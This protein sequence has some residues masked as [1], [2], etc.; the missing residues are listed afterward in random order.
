MV[1]IILG[2]F[3]GIS[4]LNLE[5]KKIFG[6]KLKPVL[7]SLGDS[8]SVRNWYI[9]HSLAK[10]LFAMGDES[11]SAGA[12]YQCDTIVNQESGNS[13]TLELLDGSRSFYIIDEPYICDGCGSSCAIDGFSVCSYCEDTGFC[14]ACFSLLRAGNLP[15]NLC[16]P[17]HNLVLITPRPQDVK[18]RSLE[19]RSMLYVDGE[20]LTVYD[21]KS[22]LEAKYEL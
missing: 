10:I 17:K 19:H 13:A 9:F 14:E 1:E 7:D 2:Q 18:V 11:Y 3:Y 21:F 12:I 6:S 8:S 20:W 5:A 16:H 15:V 4:G 22:R